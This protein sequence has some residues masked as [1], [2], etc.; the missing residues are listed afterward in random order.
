M[1]HLVYNLIFK[2]AE[3]DPNHGEL[4]RGILPDTCNDLTDITQ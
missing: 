2:Q 4:T 3:E 1:L